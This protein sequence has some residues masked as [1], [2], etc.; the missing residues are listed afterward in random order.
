MP[1]EQVSIPQGKYNEGGSFHDG[2]AWVNI[3]SAPAN[4][5]VDYDIDG[6]Y[7]DTSG[8]MVIPRSSIGYDREIPD[9][10][11]SDFIDGFSVLQYVSEV[12]HEL[13]SIVIDTDG[14]VV[15]PPENYYFLTNNGDGAFVTG[16]VYVG[17][18]DGVID[19]TGNVIVPL[20]YNEVRKSSEGMYAVQK[21]G[22]WGFCDSHGNE[23][24]P[25]Q[26]AWVSDFNGG[27][28]IRIDNGILD[29]IDMNGTVIKTIIGAEG[30][31]VPDPDGI[32]W[33]DFPNSIEKL[34]GDMMQLEFRHPNNGL[35][36]YFLIN[37]SGNIIAYHEESLPGSQVI[38]KTT[39][40]EDDFYDKVPGVIITGELHK[41]DRD[42][43]DQT[44]RIYNYNG[45][46][47]YAYD[48]YDSAPLDDSYTDSESAYLWTKQSTG[49]YGVIQVV[50]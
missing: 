41:Y 12:S 32:L 38:K 50:Y 11:D 28:A 40:F 35:E 48:S 18:L 17:A 34:N 14:R 24:I 27:K 45:D 8:N 44:F 21:N 10:D 42:Y 4:N 6:G 46:G 5:Q 22:L 13:T 31:L 1:P 30:S 16:S 25:V 33:T 3:D 23:V 15:I 2:L 29:M 49:N 7:I 43:A 19:T 37:N 47:I 39:V 9:N 20:Q 26:Y 36:V